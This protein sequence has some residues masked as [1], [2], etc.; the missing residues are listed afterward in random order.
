LKV[1]YGE[2]YPLARLLGIAH[3][4]YVTH[5]GKMPPTTNYTR[6]LNCVIVDV[7]GHKGLLFKEGEDCFDLL[8]Q[9]HK[10]RLVDWVE[11]GE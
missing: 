3:E 4:I 6:Y 2:D 8:P 1:L 11:E 9:V 10:D 7:E 5:I